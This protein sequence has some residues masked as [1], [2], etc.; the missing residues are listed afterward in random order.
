MVSPRGEWVYTIVED[1]TL[2]CLSIF[3]RN[4]EHTMQEW[5][6]WCAV[7]CFFGGGDVH[8]TF[9]HTHTHTYVHTI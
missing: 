7:F 8:A 3:I 6:N 2:Y 9:T 5:V 4:L 1:H